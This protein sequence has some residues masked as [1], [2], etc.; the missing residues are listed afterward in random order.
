MVHRHGVKSLRRLQIA[1]SKGAAPAGP[2]KHEIGELYREQQAG[3]QRAQMVDE[4]L[5]TMEKNDNE[6]VTSRSW[7]LCLIWDEKHQASQDLVCWFQVSSSQA[8]LGGSRPTAARL[9]FS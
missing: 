8:F 6:K 3:E 1:Q 5:R 2:Q 7:S 9:F 4:S